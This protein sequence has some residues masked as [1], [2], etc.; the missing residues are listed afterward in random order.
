MSIYND[1]GKNI[2]LM[3]KIGYD[4][5]EKIG[6][7]LQGSI[8]RSIHLS[9]NKKV[10]IKMADI[11]LHSQSIVL[12]NNIKIKVDE[13]ILSEAM[14]LKSLSSHSKCPQSIIKYIGSC[15]RYFGFLF[16]FI[17]NFFG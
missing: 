11:K 12:V 9:T 1:H 15:K 5:F 6:N 17:F 13:N 3:K 16:F 8:W 4:H 14:I 10:V 7:T 2:K